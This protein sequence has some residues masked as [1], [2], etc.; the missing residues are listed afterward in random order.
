[1][2]AAS[3]SAGNLTVSIAGPGGLCGESPHIGYVDVTRGP[4]FAPLW[5]IRRPGDNP[6][7]LTSF[8]YGVLPAGFAQDHPPVPIAPGDEVH[9]DVNAPGLRGGLTV[10][11][12]P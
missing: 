6:P 7:P 11:V 10:T 3:T 8:T 5:T 4:R 12:T 1:M 9:I 2:S